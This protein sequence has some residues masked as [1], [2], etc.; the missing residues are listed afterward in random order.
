MSPAASRSHTRTKI[1][2]TIGPASAAPEQV[3]ALLDVG[4]DV[5]RVNCAHGTHETLQ[6]FI[7]TLRTRAALK[8][9]PLAILADLAGPK[10]RVGR[11]ADGSVELRNGS[12]F[13]LTTEEVMGT[14]E[15]ACV[16]YAGLPRDVRRGDVVF[17][18]DGL[19]RLAVREVSGHE[20]H[21]VVEVGGWLSDLKGL[22]VPTAQI[23]VPSLT[24]KDWRDV[25]FLVGQEVDY[26][27]LSFVRSEADIQLLRDG[28]R[29]R[30]R[31][32][33]ILAKI[34]KGQAVERLEAIVAA[35][36]AVMVA[37]GDLGVECAIEEVPVLQ[38][39]IIRACNEAAKPVITATQML[40]SM[41]G[42]PRP[43][44]AEASDV[45]NAVLDGT[46][47][48]ML[49]AETATGR[50]PVDAVRVMRQII[51]NSEAFRRGESRPSWAEARQLTVAE[52]IG[53][54][55]CLAAESTCAAAIICLTQSGATTRHLARWRP[56]Q[57]ILSVTPHRDTWCA[58]NLVWGVEPIYAD[59][60]GSNFDE[61]CARIIALLCER[62]RLSPGSTVVV[63]AGLPFS[64]HGRTNTVRIEAV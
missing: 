9:R 53:R 45:A 44:R 15:R 37:R 14:A 57:P 29:S 19:I 8:D 30:G 62:G 22:S 6:H 11:F 28:L 46:D 12:A 24:D 1:V 25:D 23:R 51:A 26:L 21:T 60:F 43:T 56:E 61:A 20:I 52:A 55:A 64:E 16:N 33:P 4:M 7:A 58:L 41:V 48:V 36:D 18:N 49:S 17:L 35:A 2:V 40:E 42:N 13:T 63:T 32:L 47:A 50:Y 3:D 38:K 34:E 59:V 5:A 39:Q 31:V 54:S 27:G 10:L